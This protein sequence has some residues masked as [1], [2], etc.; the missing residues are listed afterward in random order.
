MM[1]DSSVWNKADIL[2]DAL[3]DFLNAQF[4]AP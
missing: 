3:M 4:P 1:F 2:G